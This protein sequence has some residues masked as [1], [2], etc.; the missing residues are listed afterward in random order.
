MLYEHYLNWIEGEEDPKNIMAKYE[1]VRWQKEKIINNAEH[2]QEFIKQVYN[3]TIPTEGKKVFDQICTPDYQLFFGSELEI[4]KKYHILTEILE[5]GLL[6]GIDSYSDW[7]FTIDNYD[8]FNYGFKGIATGK[9]DNKIP[10]NFRFKDDELFIIKEMK[11]KFEIGQKINATWASGRITSHI[12]TGIK[13]T[14]RGFWYI[15][16]SKTE[17]TGLHECHIS[18]I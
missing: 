11:P 6:S 10:Y 13:L 12:I 8:A 5:N 16:D 17:Q 1:F 15:W 4:G 14:D 18:K 7:Y 3:N 9:N 2:N